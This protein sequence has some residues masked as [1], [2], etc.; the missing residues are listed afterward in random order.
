MTP[1]E[2]IDQIIHESLLYGYEGEPLEDA[3]IKEAVAIV[4]Q[5]VDG[6]TAELRVVVDKLPKTADG[7]PIVPGMKVYYPLMG[8]RRGEIEGSYI[9]NHLHVGTQSS[10]SKPSDYC[11]YSTREAA[12]EAQLLGAYCKEK[13]DD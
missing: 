13:Q 3:D 10:N 1:E 7:V 8:N 5:C 9:D 12:K 11:W 2:A 4:E 6:T